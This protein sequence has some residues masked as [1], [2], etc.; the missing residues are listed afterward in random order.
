MPVAQSE[1]DAPG[2][3]ILGTTQLTQS[4][5]AQAWVPPKPG[6]PRVCPPCAHRSY[7]TDEDLEDY[8]SHMI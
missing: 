2:E 5:N 6:C 3:V 8:G 1:I 7:A 4:C